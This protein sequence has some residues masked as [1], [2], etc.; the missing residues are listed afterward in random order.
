MENEVD[1]LLKRLKELGVEAKPVRVNERQKATLQKIV[2]AD[3]AIK[4]ARETIKQATEN[5]R[6][7]RET[8]D[9]LLVEARKMKVTQ[10]EIGKALGISNGSVSSRT[11]TARRRVRKRNRTKK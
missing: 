8:L 6:V 9:R 3:V 10:A 11:I 5:W 7:S 1:V 4:E 2:E